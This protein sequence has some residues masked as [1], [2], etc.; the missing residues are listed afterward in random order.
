MPW[1]DGPLCPTCQQRVAPPREELKACLCGQ[2]YAGLRSDGQ[3]VFSGPE[4][5]ELVPVWVPFSE[6]LRLPL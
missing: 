3:L 6:Q 4:G 1:I 2:T 5:V